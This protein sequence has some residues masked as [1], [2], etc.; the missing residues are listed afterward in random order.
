[1]AGGGDVTEHLERT[2]GIVLD[3]CNCHE[4][5]HDSISGLVGARSRGPADDALEICAFKVPTSAV[6]GPYLF[7]FESDVRKGSRKPRPHLFSI[8][9]PLLAFERRSRIESRG[10]LLQPIGYSAR[11]REH[12]AGQWLSLPA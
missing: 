7:F 3:V 5:N 11:F 4:E 12:H 10:S 8:K 2:G 9:Y 6:G 1:M